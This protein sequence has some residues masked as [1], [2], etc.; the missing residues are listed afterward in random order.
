MD[1]STPQV[2][3]NSASAAVAVNAGTGSFGF[4]MTPST[5]WV[6]SGNAA[7]LT[8]T[9]PSGTGAGT[10]GYSF[11]TNTA[12]S[13]RTGVITL[14]GQSHTVTQAGVTATLSPSAAAAAATAGTGSFDLTL[15][16]PIAWTATS[17][18]AWLTVTTPSGTGSGPVT[19]SFTSN[20]TLVSRTGVITVAGQT[21]TVTQAGA[22]ASLSS[23]L[24]IV[25]SA[26]GTGT[27]TLSLTS[28]AAWTATSS[29]AWLTVTPDSGNATST[30]TYT[31][32][33]NSAVGLREATITIADKTFLLRQLGTSAA[34]TTWGT[35]GNGEIRTIA[36]N[37]VSG[38]SGDGGDAT[39]ASI[40]GLNGLAADRQG[41]L[42]FV[43]TTNHRIRRVDARTGII[44]TYAGGGSNSG[45]GLPATFTALDQPQG[46]AFDPAG[47]LIV[48]DTGDGLVRRINTTTGIASNIFGIGQA[49]TSGDG[50][51]AVQAAVLIPRGVAV[52]RSGNIFISDGSHRVRRID[53]VT[54]I[55]RT[56]AGT[57]LAGFSGD[58]GLATSAQL[59][60]PMG[61]ATDAAGNLYIADQG[62]SRVRKVDV[63]SGIINT[64][65]G[66]GT[67]TVTPSGEGIQAKSGSL[68]IPS[69]VA[70]DAA[71]NLFIADVTTSRIRRVDNAGVIATL[72]GTGTPG[73]SGD[74][75][76][77]RL[78]ALNKPNGITFNS[79]G[80]LFISDQDN[81][82]IRLVDG[83]TP[84][85]TLSP[86]SAQVAASAGTGTFNLTMTPSGPWTAVS[87]AAWLTI[88]NPTGTG[89]STINYS[90]AL[91]A[92][93]TPRTATISVLGQTFTLTQAGVV[94]TLSPSGFSPS[95]AAGSGAF[96]LTLNAPM[97]WTATSNAAWL[98]VTTP[99]G[100]GSGPVSYTFATNSTFASRTG[101]ITVAGLTHTVRQA[102][103]T[104]SLAPTSATV[105][106]AAGNGTVNLSLSAAVPWTA[107]SSASWLTVSPASG[108]GNA[109]LTFT[110]A[111]NPGTDARLAA[112][113]V[114]GKSF[115][116]AQLGTLER[117]TPW[118]ATGYG[119]IRTIAGNGGFS[120]IVDGG[121][122]TLA[123]VRNPYDVAVDRNGNVYL[124]DLINHLVRRVDATTGTISTVAG[125]GTFGFAGDG[126]PATAA[127]LASPRGLALDAT[128][129]LYIADNLNH[130]IRR[131]DALTGIITTLAGTGSSQP[132]ANAGPAI[133]SS[134]PFPVGLAFDPEGNLAVSESSSRVRRI[135]FQTG[136][137]STIAGTVAGFS[138]DGG[139]AKLA[140]LNRPQGVAFD[141][142]GNLFIADQGNSRVR[143]VDVST[144]IISTVAGNDPS[145]VTAAPASP[146]NVFLYPDSVAIG[147]SGNLFISDD[148]LHRIIEI[149]LANGKLYHVSG[150]EVSGA[151]TPG[152]SGD[153]QKAQ[154][155]ALYNPRGLATDSLGNLYLADSR[156]NR[157]RFI[158]FSSPSVPTPTVGVVEN[159]ADF[160]SSV[161]PGSLA[162][163]FGSQFA[164]AN[165]SATGTPWP[166]VL[167]GL[168]VTVNGVLAPIQFVSPGRV[169]IQIPY[170]TATGTATMVVSRYGTN[171][172]SYTFSV[173]PAAPG[174][175]EIFNADSSVN[176]QALP[177][178]PASTVTVNYTGAGP[179]SPAVAD[180]AAGPASPISIPTLPTS[181]TLG[182]VSVVVSSVS[183]AQGRVGVAQMKLVVPSTL[184]AGV[185][186][187]VVT[188]NGVASS[189][190]RSVYVSGPAP[191]LVAIAPDV[192]V[193]GDPNTTVSILG[194]NFGSG[195]VV[196]WQTPGG[197]TVGLSATLANSSTL[198]AVV[199]ASLLATAGIAQVGVIN[200]LGVSSNK[201]PYLI[202]PFRVVAVSPDVIPVNSPDTPLTFSGQNMG[203]TASVQ[204]TAPGGI[205]TT[206]PASLVQFAQV[207]ATLPA[208]ALT[209]A[210]TAQVALLNA[211]G[212]KTNSLALSITPFTITGITPGHILAGSAQTSITVTGQ[213]L[214]TATG[215]YFLPIQGG[216][217]L[218]A[219]LTNVQDTQV[220]ASLP[221]AFLATAGTARVFLHDGNQAASNLLFFYVTPFN[222]DSVTPNTAA[223][224]DPALPVTISGQNLSSATR[225]VFTPPGGASVSLS[226]SLIQAAQISATL[227]SS[228]MSTAGTAQIALADGTGA[229]SNR[230]PFIITT[231]IPPSSTTLTSSVSPAAP[232]GQ[233]LTLT[234]TVTPNTA[235]GLVTFYDRTTILGVRPLTNG[236][237]TLNTSLLPTGLAAPRAY[238]AGNASNRPSAS[239]QLGLNIQPTAAGGFAPFVS[240]PVSPIQFFNAFG[241]GDFNGDGTA[242]LIVTTSSSFQFLAGNRDGTFAAP[243]S[244]TASGNLVSVAVADFN[245]DGFTDLAFADMLTSVTL[246]RGNGDGTFAAPV[247]ILT[248][249]DFRSLAATDFNGDGMADLAVAGS[250]A[251]TV[252]LGNGNGAFA[253]PRTFPAGAGARYLTIA[254]FNGDT[255]PDVAVS[256][257]AGINFLAGTGN[258]DL[259]SAGFVAGVTTITAI[260]SRDMSNDGKPDLAVSHSTGAAFLRG[261]GDG[262]FQAE[263]NY[264][265]DGVPFGI[266]VG[267]L[268]GNSTLDLAVSRNGNISFLRGLGEGT[269]QLPINFPAGTRPLGLVTGDFNGDGKS[270]LA[271][272]D[273]S[274][275]DIKVFLGATPVPDLAITKSHTG[276]FVQGQN[277]ATYRIVVS[278]VGSA[279]TTGTITVTD[280]LPAGLTATAISGNNWTCTLTPLACTHNIAMDAGSVS[281]PITIAVN[282][283]ANAPS[284]LTN[285]AVVSGGGDTNPANNSASDVTTILIPQTI[286]FPSLSNQALGTPPFEISATAT[287]GLKVL[288]NATTPGVCTVSGSVVTLVSTGNCS[289]TATQLG[290]SAYAVAT[291]VVRNFNVTAAQVCTYS[292]SPADATAALN[293]GP[294][295]LR[296]R[297]ASS[298]PWSATSNAA[299]LTLT[300]DK[301]GSGTTEVNYLAA[302][303]TT[304]SER[305]GTI[306]VA[307]QTFTVRQFSAA[308]S[309]ALNPSSVDLTAAGGSALIALSTS[310]SGCNYT[311]TSSSPANV[312][313]SPATGSAP[314]QITVTVAANTSTSARNFNATIGG[315]TLSIRQAGTACSVALATS[316][317]S[318][319]ASGGP[320]SVDITTPPGCTWN[321]LSG[322]AWVTITSGATGTGPAGTLFFSVDPNVTTAP[323]SGALTIGGQSFQITQQGLACELSLNTAGLPSPLPASGGTGSLA[324]T[325]SNQNCSWT[326]GTR[327]SWLTISAP[328]SGSGDGL[329][330]L[331][332][333][334]N[335]ASSPRSTLLYIGG[336]AVTIS[337]A[338]TLCAF[339]LRSPVGSVPAS[340]GS[341]SVG[342]LAPGTCPWTSTSNAAWLT[343]TASGSSGN[344]DV[345]FTATANTSAAPRTG[346][347]TIAGQTYTVT[348]AGVPCAFTLNLASTTVTAAGLSPGTFTVSTTAAGC[349]ARAVS[350]S[351]WVTATTAF[352]GQA[353]TVTY[354]VAPNLSGAT[355]SAIIKLA[356]QSFTVIQNGAACSFTLSSRGAVFGQAG[357]TGNIVATA[358]GANCTPTVG[359]SGFVS[360]G[361]LTGPASG[362]FTQPFTVPAF[363]SASN[364]VRTVRITVGGKT[365]YIKQASW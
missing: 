357:G 151:P 261:N 177:A 343:I 161:A 189:V 143:K 10:I 97:P 279:R 138:G 245:G 331:T 187:L 170:G 346:T 27:F 314:A 141:A 32:L 23:P 284:S 113:S 262:T 244:Y 300:S 93:L 303:N 260:A 264:P 363:V 349:T 220:T 125:T 147:R 13:P 140:Q 336:H 309:Y 156:N 347:L 162:Y 56:V 72:A 64:V 316:S 217:P 184:S 168:T 47:N 211:A 142:V 149:D 53:A 312:T 274:A 354:V 89:N 355:R 96:N 267:D 329:L 146:T 214:S 145:A 315:Q 57:G 360:L 256:F 59:N 321:S 100:T 130:R 236:V 252:L 116:V 359:P 255:K 311:S 86:A 282:V 287:S 63:L 213:N 84:T 221:A 196:S 219:S 258:G 195:T 41:N 227:P 88:T 253:A 230:L 249:T 280:T 38:F 202:A 120:P 58:T 276:A 324:I 21:H 326:S 335:A 231:A 98:T 246:V 70:V 90:F 199:P 190:P 133:T 111:A 129:N 102:G 46:L 60:T 65:A 87:D 248:G 352:S 174:L 291:P 139:D 270:D 289:I 25:G 48:T 28:P 1:L 304:G 103:V 18:A 173:L 69:A 115:S 68:P 327:A 225:V 313:L 178:A 136:D 94:A 269:F 160:S 263:V 257:D 171:S 251:I 82:R 106:A 114:A 172:N 30:L 296:I 158:D 105:S 218:H 75:G 362:A 132:S 61:L 78:A 108:T 36:G 209:S 358:S 42:F 43:D 81:L 271:T 293:G 165:A 204:F 83:A 26:A 191:T 188:T 101:T 228:L 216:T 166:T 288:L 229:L 154:S 39:S 119:N 344:G 45:N 286:T 12:L 157:I 49:S 325:T 163:I 85:A 128:G 121:L 234:A 348:Q 330:A 265:M 203:S 306:S 319:P 55:V 14:V 77:A 337:Q 137:I 299:W 110:Y 232:F 242:D 210:G 148:Q 318:L 33:A 356:D 2:V 123:A 3:L 292:L 144:G 109:T 126:G 215:L 285:T 305:S 131:V 54:G 179:V 66:D 31:Y 135:S 193:A 302:P 310:G 79:E 29:A 183:L 185:Y 62:N 16:T 51:P 104:S 127:L 176:S 22:T 7:W 167:A 322:P 332:A 52:D 197:T 342:V 5:L 283:S 76:Q 272:S 9:N 338:G 241:S 273:V 328:G 134:L 164:T 364:A 297:T 259:A 307:D 92:S 152:F 212:N 339:Q 200:G 323:R 222:I 317:T 20:P 298:C 340:G 40:R 301:S 180:G 15:N 226:P 118:G 208:S 6:A 240:Y 155:A 238:Y 44:S 294:G 73:F 192:A 34:Y 223:V 122:A 201:L 205:V 150:I 334:A 67:F 365:F 341:G 4:T 80:N 351:D 278:S 117:Y 206:V 153:G 91:N 50:G 250:N 295:S 268:D 107:T 8:V 333:S 74:G 281:Q 124:T 235:T 320:G 198:T 19:Y 181:A 345:Q 112:I 243:V 71:G 99:S 24:A 353:G 159:G 207:Q 194:A 290:N 254:D 247:V 175:L 308:C 35:R 37:G 17:N 277:G 350:F 11:T 95:A 186:P 169:D 361:I 233:T 237:A 224:G 182:G 239:P 275:N 266:A